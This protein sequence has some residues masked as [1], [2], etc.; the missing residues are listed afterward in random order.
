MSMTHMTSR[1]FSQSAV[2]SRMNGLNF[3]IYIEAL[4]WAGIFIG[5]AKEPTHVTETNTKSKEFDWTILVSISVTRANPP[6]RP[7][8]TPALPARCNR[9]DCGRGG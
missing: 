2:P 1:S 7:T 5:R 8:K 4:A 3:S 6:T 9:G